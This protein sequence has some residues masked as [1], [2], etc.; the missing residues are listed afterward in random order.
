MKFSLGSFLK[1][2]AS[3]LIDGISAIQGGHHS[4]QKFKKI[5]LPLL[6]AIS[7]AFPSVALKTADGTLE[8]SAASLAAIS[9]EY[10]PVFRRPFNTKLFASGLKNRIPRKIRLRIKPQFDRTYFM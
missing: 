4:A 8:R 1:Y 3:L 7:M 10:S 9:G 6:S 5:T 2:V